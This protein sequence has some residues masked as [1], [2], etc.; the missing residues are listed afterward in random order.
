[1]LNRGHFGVLPPAILVLVLTIFGL[2]AG[3][4]EKDIII[5][6]IMYHP[7]LEMEDL[8]YIELFNR[9]DTLVDISRWSFTKGITYV[10]PAQTKIEPGGFLVVCRNTKVFAGNYGTQINVTG[11][12]TGKLS[13]GGEKI[14]L[15]NGAGIIID[16]VKYADA[17]PW[18]SAP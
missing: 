10:F 8:Q 15:S 4:G 13:H 3:A 16:S 6:E 17:A 18:T 14:E 7:P 2:S 5:N 9:G 12:F 11:D 1:M